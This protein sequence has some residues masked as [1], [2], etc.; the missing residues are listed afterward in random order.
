ML[1]EVLAILWRQAVVEVRRDQL[2]DLL[3][4]EFSFRLHL[5][6]SSRAF[7]TFARAR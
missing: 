6:Y 7:R 1:L 2:H 5:M 4:C 3:T